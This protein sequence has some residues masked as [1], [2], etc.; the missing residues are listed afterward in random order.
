MV[1]GRGVS[2]EE[3]A[4]SNGGAECSTGVFSKSEGGFGGFILPRNSGA[5]QWGYAR[6]RDMF[7]PRQLSGRLNSTR[8]V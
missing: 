1:N 8:Y 7:N 3:E 2:L 5:V 6:Y 4:S